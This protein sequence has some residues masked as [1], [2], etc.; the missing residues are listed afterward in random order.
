MAGADNEP[1]LTPAELAALL[2][3]DV[4]TT[5]RWAKG[6]KLHT[7]RTPGGHYRFFENEV[8]ALMRGETWELPPE[9]ANAA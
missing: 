3:V 8:K 5:S 6:G 9:Y 2:R 1:L 7:I 4:K